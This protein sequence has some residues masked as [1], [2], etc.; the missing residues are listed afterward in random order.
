MGQ[1]VTHLH[2]TLPDMAFKVYGPERDE[3]FGDNDSFKIIEGGVLK[4]SRQD[5]TNRYIT[6]GLWASIEEKPAASA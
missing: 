4:I 1:L 2:A 3:E 6:P 5:G